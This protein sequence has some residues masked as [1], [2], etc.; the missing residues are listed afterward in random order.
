MSPPGSPKR[1]LGRGHRAIK[2]SLRLREARETEALLTQAQP[3]LSS[4]NERQSFSMSEGHQSYSDLERE[5][6]S[7]RASIAALSVPFPGPRLDEAERNR[8]TPLRR[9][10]AGGE[11]LQ[12]DTP[13][14]VPALARTSN[15]TR[16][17]L[18]QAVRGFERTQRET[19]TNSPRS[20]VKEYSPEVST[21]SAASVQDTLTGLVAALRRPELPSL[22]PEVF[23][24]DIL[25]YP[26]WRCKV[27]AILAKAQMGEFER[28][29][30]LAHYLRGR[31]RTPVESLLMVEAEGC[32]E[33]AWDIL[34][35]R[36]GNRDQIADAYR[37]R[38]D[39]WPKVAAED[40]E[41]L[42]DFG[43][44]L[45]QCQVAQKALKSLARLDDMSENRRLVAK[46][47]DWAARR[48]AR[49][50][51]QC[52][53]E[54]YPTFGQFVKFVVEEAKYACGPLA[55]T[56]KKDSKVEHRGARERKTIVFATGTGQ[57]GCRCLFCE[58]QGHPT[59]ECRKL[60]GQPDDLKRGALLRLR[61]CFRCLETG[62]MARSCTRQV[63]CKKCGRSH[64][65]VAHMDVLPPA[66]KAVV[67][68]AKVQR[69]G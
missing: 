52:E 57:E 47:P 15:R 34:N 4:Y 63:S 23:E 14:R 30:T 37:G 48:W 9:S 35:A 19:R 59:A 2:P 62:H 50:V 32:Y 46:L 43:D 5:V 29:Q 41:A 25:K 54:E 21:A 27:R 8:R 61:L 58:T 12:V 42:R 31:A 39:E 40:G 68:D 6:E 10:S 22:V 33:E 13:Y 38:L 67:R 20:D 55:Q 45:K 26:A 60:E 18:D 69:H 17:G 51:S 56:L 65:T 3:E 64:L 24:G 66:E 1:N 53:E 11:N 49:I 44:Y 28:L 16:Q 7:L 36:F